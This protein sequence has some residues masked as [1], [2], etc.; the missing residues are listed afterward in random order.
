M[1]GIRAVQPA[2][3]RRGVGRQRHQTRGQYGAEEGV[4]LLLVHKA[5]HHSDN[6]SHQPR[7]QA[8]QQGAA[9]H[10]AEAQTRQ[11]IPQIDRGCGVA[12]PR[13]QRLLQPRHSRVHLRPFRA[14][15]AAQL[16]ELFQLL[17]I[18]AVE[19]D[20]PH[21]HQR[22]AVG[23]LQT[24]GHAVG[25]GEHLALHAVGA[26]NAVDGVLHPER[27]RPGHGQMISHSD[28]QVGQQIVVHTRFLH[29]IRVRRLPPPRPT[30]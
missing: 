9:E 6:K 16:V 25:D 28:R 27:L 4:G 21:E 3:P 18:V 10:E 2:Q 20:A 8:V 11:Q 17:Q 1:A 29:F 22:L 24:D 19:A 15:A 23:R 30:V 12:P 7:P 26:E 14:D 5:G 13:R